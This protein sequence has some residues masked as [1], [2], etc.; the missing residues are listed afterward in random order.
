MEIYAAAETK[1]WVLPAFN[2]ENLT[3]TE[4]VLAAA[5]EFGEVPIIIGI[6]NTYG[7]RPAG[8]VHTP[9]AA[10]GAWGCGCF[11]PTCAN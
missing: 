7:H 1:R 11:W 10:I 3:T 4:A 9:T 2:S 5:R 8:S 6:T